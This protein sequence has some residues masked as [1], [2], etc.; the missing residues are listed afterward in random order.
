[1]STR[2]G[3]PSFDDDDELPPIPSKD[4]I[5]RANAAGEVLGFVSDRGR[6]PKSQASRTKNF[7][8][9]FHIRVREEDRERFNELAYRRRVPKGELFTMLLDAAEQLERLEQASQAKNG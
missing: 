7:S 8:A 4:V 1:M 6:S 5:S 9:N 3:I 2:A